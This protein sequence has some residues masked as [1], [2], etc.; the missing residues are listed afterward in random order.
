MLKRLD[1]K[2]QKDQAKLERA[3]RIESRRFERI[4]MSDGA[5]D[6]KDDARSKSDPPVDQDEQRKPA[7]AAFASPEDKGDV[8]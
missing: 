2:S 3:L 5:L 4:L 6:L 1:D 8:S 7:G